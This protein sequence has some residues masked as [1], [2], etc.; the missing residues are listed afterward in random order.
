MFLKRSIFTDPRVDTRAREAAIAFFGCALSQS[1]HTEEFHPQIC[2]KI[3]SRFVYKLNY[4]SFRFCNLPLS[5][6]LN[7]AW[8]LNVCIFSFCKSGNQHRGTRKWWC[9]IITEYHH[10]GKLS[11]QVIIVYWYCHL[12][13]SSSQGIVI[14][15]EEMK[16]IWK[17]TQTHTR[18]F[19]IRSTLSK[20]ASTL[21]S[22]EE[23][24]PFCCIRGCKGQILITYDVYL[25]R[26][27]GGR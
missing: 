26:V 18:T 11:P 13:Q 25:Q 3:E 17:V 27:E 6:R 4:S 19:W 10:H 12:R 15:Q 16:R 5:W 2:K 23:R 7:V 20:M 24:E 8:Q 21:T 14:A 1:N 22:A 9:I